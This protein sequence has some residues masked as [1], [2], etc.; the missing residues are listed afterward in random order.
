AWLFLP[1]GTAS[2][3][4][5]GSW[6]RKWWGGRVFAAR[7]GAFSI[8][9]NKQTEVEYLEAAAEATAAEQDAFV[10]EY[11]AETDDDPPPLADHNGKITIDGVMHAMVSCTSA[12]S[13]SAQMQ[14]R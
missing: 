11:G 14:G 4:Q 10:E 8:D 7:M 13:A 6:L 9:K 12:V 1:G 2:A 3:V 5:P